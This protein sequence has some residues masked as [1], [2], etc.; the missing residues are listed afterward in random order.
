[1]L[2]QTAGFRFGGP[3]TQTVK[4]L[5]I[6]NGG[7]FLFQQF[8]N[9]FFPGVI[10]NFFGLSQTGLISN[11]MIW[12]IFTY[13]F[14]HGGWFHIIFN[15]LVL[16]MFGGDLED[17]WGKNLFLHYYIFSGVGAGVFI[18][19][20]NYILYSN[21][22]LSPPT[23]GASGAIFG[24]L[25]AYALTWP[26][27]EVL[28][29]FLIPVKVKYL[30][31]GLGVMEFFGTLSTV[32]GSGGNISHIGH[33]GG[34]ISGYIYIVYKSKK[35]SSENLFSK[36]ISTYFNQKLKDKRIK[37]KQKEIETR[38][39]AKKIIDNLLE[40]IARDGMSSLSPNERRNLE[41]ARKHYYPENGDIV[42]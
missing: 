2:Q 12:Q 7:I 27:R 37:K 25:L 23:I 41:W 13:M 5:L 32:S 28:L 30:I 31:I 8:C 14:L 19:I 33:L 15:L 34:I 16:W 40:K 26:N 21:Y 1:M 39:K 22:G 3:L 38:I 18:A 10:E 4:K 24:I 36:G 11:F 17:R 20:I 42:H 29:Y 9:L 6:I 35:Q